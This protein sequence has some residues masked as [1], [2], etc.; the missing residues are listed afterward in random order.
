MDD[1]PLQVIKIV[2]HFGPEIE[3]INIEITQVT[4]SV[5]NNL[6]LV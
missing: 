4:G 1:E 5:A 3:H 2:E 6:S